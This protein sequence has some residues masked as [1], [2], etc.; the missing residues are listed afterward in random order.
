MMRDARSALSRS[1]RNGITGGSRIHA[2]ARRCLDAMHGGFDSTAEQAIDGAGFEPE[3]GSDFGEPVRAEL[4]L[5]AL[6]RS[7]LGLGALLG[8]EVAVA[9]RGLELVHKDLLHL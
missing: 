2:H 8:G 6:E 7:Q 1:K 5:R 9:A 4:C 3:R